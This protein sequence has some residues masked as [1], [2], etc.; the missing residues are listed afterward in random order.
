MNNLRRTTIVAL[1]MALVA[2]PTAALA[3][4]DATTETDHAVTDRETDR[5]ITDRPQTERP[6]H[7]LREIKARA[8][9]AIDRQLDALGRLRSAIANARHITDEHAGQLLGD[10]GAAAEGLQSLA[11]QIEAATTLEELRGLIEQIDDFQIGHVLAPKTHQVIAS[12][13]LVYATGKLERFSEELSDVIARFEEA[14]FD[15]A[16]A[17]RLLDEMNDNI[18]EGYRLASPVAGNVI[19]LTPRDWPDPAKSI[20]S[21]GRGDLHAAGQNVRAAHGNGVDIVHFLRQ[22]TDGTDVSTD[23]ARTDGAVTDTPPSDG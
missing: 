14:G 4:D 1:V 8:L 11:H 7:D 6:D 20:L 9:E 5:A 22:L 3:L 12:D 17:W 19:G 18:A 13:A 10:I 16:E 23:V 21:A 15:V 2:I